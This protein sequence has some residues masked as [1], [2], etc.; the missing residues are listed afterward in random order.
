MAR[1]LNI[2]PE[3]PNENACAALFV[4]HQLVPV[5]VTKMRILLSLCFGL[6]VAFGLDYGG[7]DKLPEP[8]TDIYEPSLG[9]DPTET[10]TDAPSQSLNPAH[11]VKKWSVVDRVNQLNCLGHGGLKDDFELRKCD[12][13]SLT[14][15]VCRNQCSCWNGAVKCQGWSKCSPDTVSTRDNSTRV[16]CSIADGDRR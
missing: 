12:G 6:V 3:Q 7:A 15:L 14:P 1:A 13:L 9:L 4:A 16:G 5:F 11:L 8:G 2:V 10:I